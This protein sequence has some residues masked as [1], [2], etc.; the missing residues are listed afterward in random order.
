MPDEL[1][2]TFAQMLRTT[3]EEAPWP[4]ERRMALL[5][6]LENM[7]MEN[8]DRI[9]AAIDEDF[10]GRGGPWCMLAD[11]FTGMNTLRE[12]Q[13]HLKT[14]MRPEPANAAFPWNLMGSSYCMYEPMGLILCI[15]PWNFPFHLATSAL[16]DI[17]GAGNRCVL[18]PSE[19]TPRTSALLAELVP[20]Y[21]PGKEVHAWS[22]AIRC[23]S[24]CLP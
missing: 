13:A 7:Q 15:T 22:P 18:K 6:A 12:V 11:V 14:W 4:Y 8:K 19:S 16:A 1:E 23:V 20:R 5:K 9:V 3:R 17:L 21:F 2:Q 10:G 24:Q